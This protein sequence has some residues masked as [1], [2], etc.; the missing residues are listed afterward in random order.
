MYVWTRLFWVGW[1]LG[2][3][4]FDFLRFEVVVEAEAAEALAVERAEVV[5]VYAAGVGAVQGDAGD[6][7][8][9]HDLEDDVLVAVAERRAEG[10]C[11]VGGRRS[12]EHDRL[13]AGF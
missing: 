11:R 10:I 3:C 6:V 13:L 7:E 4:C 5:E 12:V 9:G 8:V 2:C 1:R